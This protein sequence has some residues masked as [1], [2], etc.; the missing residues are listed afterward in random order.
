MHTIIHKLLN[1]G[2]GSYPPNP[3][4][5]DLLMGPGL[6]WDDEDIAWE[7]FKLM[8]PS[9]EAN[10]AGFPEPFA[11][12]WAAAVGQ[13]GL[14]ETEALDLFTRRIQLRRGY[15]VS[16]T[17]DDSQLPTEIRDDRYFRDAIV[18]DDLV[19]NKLSLDMPRARNIHMD[20][21]RAQR[22]IELEKLDVLYLQAL[23]TNDLAEQSQISALKQVLRGLPTTFDLSI[24]PTP[25]AL[26][27]AWPLELTR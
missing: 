17:I 13:G 15:T 19:P 5:M 1:G 10:W 11:F 22:D 27:A 14:T 23:E 16:A 7:A 20:H 6:G 18:W 2:V 26:K 8:M 24:Y 4:V 21:I 12:E 25:E 9:L 3:E